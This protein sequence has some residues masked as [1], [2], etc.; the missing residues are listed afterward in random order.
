[1]IAAGAGQATS[2]IMDCRDEPGNDKQVEMTRRLP[3]RARQ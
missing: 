2:V 1:M 3:G